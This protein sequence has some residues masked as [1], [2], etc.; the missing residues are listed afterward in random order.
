MSATS[1]TLVIAGPLSPVER[2]LISK[3]LGSRVKPRQVRHAFVNGEPLCY[4]G[5][6]LETAYS[7]QTRPVYSPT[8]E[9]GQPT[10]SFCRSF[11]KRLL[12]GAV[13]LGRGGAR[14]GVA[15]R[16]GRGGA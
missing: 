7:S 14:A 2:V 8:G 1:F 3:G 12:G 11:V 15:R 13:L 16:G 4:Q 5:T 9:T 10:C 6:D